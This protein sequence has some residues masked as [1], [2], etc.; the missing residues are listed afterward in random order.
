MRK[1]DASRTSGSGARMVEVRVRGRN[2]ASARLAVRRSFLAL[3]F[4]AS[5]DRHHVA[6]RWSAHCLRPTGTTPR[7]Q[8]HI[9]GGDVE[10]DVTFV[11]ANDALK[12]EIDR[13][14]RTKYRRYA[15]NI[16]NSVLTPRARSATLRLVPRETARA[17]SSGRSPSGKS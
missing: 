3:R 13:A 14:Y 5:E 4:H 10:K 16:V 6:E 2:F 17:T 15:T 11:K 8:G 9:Q 12:D 1:Y 7:H